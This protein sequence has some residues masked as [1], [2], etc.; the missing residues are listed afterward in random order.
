VLVRVLTPLCW[1]LW[2]ILFLVALYGLVSVST[3]QTSSPEARRGLGIFA[4]LFLMALLAVAA[5]LLN[6]A[7]R[8]QSPAGLITMTLVLAYPL[9]SLV[10]HPAIQAYKRRGFASAEARVGD[11]G[12]SVDRAA[13]PVTIDVRFTLTDLDSRPLAGQPVRLVVGSEPGWQ[14]PDAGSA[15]SLTRTAST[16]SARKRSLTND[17]ARCRRTS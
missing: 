5:I 11:S 14:D 17:C 7:A 16:A 10:A 4:T 8:K 15:S 1:T 2:G 13:A 9:V 3:E 12:V 6:V